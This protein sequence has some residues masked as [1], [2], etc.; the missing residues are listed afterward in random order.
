MGTQEIPNIPRILSALAECAACITMFFLL[1]RKPVS[2]AKKIF[3]VVILPLQSVYM[4]AT[5]NLSDVLWILSMAGVVVLMVLY[6]FIL[7]DD[8]LKVALFYGLQSFIIAELGA[9]LGWQVYLYT[10]WDESNEVSG[11]YLFMVL[12]YIL[13]YLLIAKLFGGNRCV[14]DNEEISNHEIWTVFILLVGM[15]SISNIG[16]NK[17]LASSVLGS[18]GYTDT[19]YIVRTI[20]DIGGVAILYAYNRQRRELW[21]RRELAAMQ[22]V[23]QN[24][25]LQYQQMKESTDIINYK[26]HDLKHQIAVL[27][28]ENDP[29]QRNRFLDQM[30]ED[31]HQY[32]VQ[33]KTGNDIVD[34]ILT[35][36]NIICEKKHIAMNCVVDG[37]LLNFMSIM[38]LCSVMGNALDNAIECE[39]KIE[40]PDK[41][42]IHVAIYAQNQFVFLRFENYFEGALEIVNGLPVTH[43]NDS[44]FHGYGLKSIR[45]IAQKYGGEMKFSYVDNWF[46]LSILIPM[47]QEEAAV[48]KR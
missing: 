39:Q 15:F 8:N 37:A 29:E 48:C 25:Y 6:L 23:L 38:D 24:Q 7:L 30:E 22:N 4:M 14:D 31:I 2:P 33:N 16:L 36:K 27:R 44:D 35:S 9:T 20:T 17:E 28:M 18:L 40:D 42:L 41:R 47:K 21:A 19:S 32:E 12:F 34:T 46:Q 45:Q 26:Y 13:F 5:M 43:K 10:V 11:G 1:N 3:L